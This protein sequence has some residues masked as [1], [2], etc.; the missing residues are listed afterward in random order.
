MG[1]GGR[2]LQRLVEI[3]ELSIWLRIVIISWSGNF[4]SNSL[5]SMI[6]I[7]FFKLLGKISNNGQMLKSKWDVHICLFNTMEPEH[8]KMSIVFCQTKQ[9]KF[10]IRMIYNKVYVW[11]DK[12][13]CRLNMMIRKKREDKSFFRKSSY[14]NLEIWKIMKR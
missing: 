10:R 2:L 9:R 1:N 11:A 4:K 5:T 13:R 14:S 3:R 6:M 8:L 7:D 12:S